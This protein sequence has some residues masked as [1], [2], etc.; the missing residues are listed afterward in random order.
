MQV[1]FM[2]HD[3]PA[4]VLQYYTESRKVRDAQMGTKDEAIDSAI[5]QPNSVLV[6]TASDATAVAATPAQTA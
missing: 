4:D 2:T 5:A 1:I 6:Q 3:L